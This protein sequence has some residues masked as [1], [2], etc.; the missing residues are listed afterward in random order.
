MSKSL[1]FLRY[2]MALL[3]GAA[4]AAPVA[5]E[6]VVRGQTLYTTYCAVCHNPGG[7]PGP[8]FI[9]KGA[10]DPSVLGIAFRTV[11][12]M[13]QFE[14]LLTTADVA[15]LAAYLAVRFDVTP[16]PQ[17]AAAIEYYHAEFDHYFVTTVADEITKLDNGTFVGWQRTGLQFDVFKAPQQGTSAVCRFFSTAFAPKSSHFY[18]ASASECDAVK[19]NPN[20]MFEGEVFHVVPPAQGGACAS[21]TIP[22]YRV[23]NDG[24][25]A[26]PNHRLM[27]DV[28]QQSEMVAKGWVPEGE[29]IGITMCVPMSDQ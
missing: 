8:E 17:T 1:P 24:M 27:T 2:L 19:A 26:A 5:A 3:V 16:V 10:G 23:Y 14:T 6:D 11:L 25:G 12:E 4:C 29:G 20:W 28:A 13:E 22:V 7:N 15:D 18:T 9:R 21:G